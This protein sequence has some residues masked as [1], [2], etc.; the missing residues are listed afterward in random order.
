[1]RRYMAVHKRESGGVR[2]IVGAFALALIAVAALAPAA[3]ANPTPGATAEA[4][5]TW[6][7]QLGEGLVST[8]TVAAWN[9]GCNHHNAYENLNG[10]ALTHE[11]LGGHPGHTS[12]GA[13]AAANSVLAEA[14]SAPSPT[15]D[16]SLL[17]GPT[18][19]GAVFHRAA[20]L[21]PRLAQI[22]FDSS[23]F[24]EGGVYRTFNCLWLQNQN[25]NP[26]QALDNTRTT[27]GLTLY[28][29]P[30]NGAYG[31]PTVFPGN[32]SP[33]P[34]QETGVPA[35]STLGWLLNVEING[36]WANGGSGFS[37][38]AHGVSATLAPDGTSNFLPLVVSQCGPSGCG[39]GG[40]TS[41]GAY[42]RGGFGIFPTQPLAAN[43][44]YRVVLTAG[45][46][47]DN[48]AK[49]DYPLA[50]Y[51]WCFSTGASYT[52]SADCAAPTTAAQEPST[53]NAS[54]APSVTPPANSGGDGSGGTGGGG[55]GGGSTGNAPAPAPGGSSNRGGG[56][57]SC[58]VPKLKGLS[59]PAARK[60]LSAAHC[61]LGKVHKAKGAGAGPVRVVGQGAKPKASLAAGA[62]VAVT[63][64]A[65][66]GASDGR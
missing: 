49:V 62:K 3:F 21:D 14:V 47:T 1:M 2:L 10:N 64:R 43:T 50:G 45:T 38:Y 27:P 23:T 37:T 24:L 53:P 44:T 63:V 61:A 52:P 5:N 55:T 29:S 12:D 51:S 40:G 39:G 6:R 22:G 13:E 11:D 66:S 54:T 8:T 35:G 19:D 7:A 15:P 41:E 57:P 4:L 31:V 42:F 33:D 36:P 60:K 28:P 20:L 16:A 65:A 32:E 17:P 34:A 58:T 25:A 48:T 56:A 46:V 26:P 18:W 59:I 9:T 30:A